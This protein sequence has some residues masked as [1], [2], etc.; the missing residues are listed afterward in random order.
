MTT[1]GYHASHEQFAPSQL[2]EYVQR[3]EQAGFEAAMCS[4]HFHPWNHTQG[5]SGFSWAWLG[6]ALQATNLPMGL[7]CAPGYRYHPAIVAQAVATLAE[8]F[9]GRIW[10]AFGSGQALNE[11][12]TGEPWPSKNERNSRLRE[13]VEIMRALWNGDTVTHHGSVDVVEATL[14]TLPDEKPSAFAAAITPATARWAAS[15]A[16]GL[17]TIARPPGELKEVV[18]AFRENGG[19]QK[20]LYL[21]VQLSY[22]RTDKQA[23]TSAHQQW[24]TNIF[25]SSVLSELPTPDHFEAAAE[26]VEPDD[27]KDHVLTSSSL[28]QHTEWLRDYEEL[29]FDALFLHNVGQNQREFISAF[30]EEVLPNL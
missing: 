11:S 20:P 27:L 15:W 1:I 26:F 14:F 22:A 29:G 28:S 21:Q 13:C 10:P 16:D 3:A 30:A 25:D 24:G 19:A 12:I 2:L 4:D 18:D 8:L 6:A 17:I 23:L 5:Q 7:V 9:P